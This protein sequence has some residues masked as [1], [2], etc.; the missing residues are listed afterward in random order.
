MIYVDSLTNTVKFY[1]SLLNENSTFLIAE[2]G[3]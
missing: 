1:H 2:A 3:E